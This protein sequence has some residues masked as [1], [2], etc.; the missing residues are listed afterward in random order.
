MEINLRLVWFEHGN[1]E[2]II[3]GARKG[4]NIEI[5]EEGEALNLLRRL[6]NMFI[7]N[8]NHCF[9]VN[10]NNSQMLE[11]H[12]KEEKNIKKLNFLSWIFE[13]NLVD[14]VS[15][16]E[17]YYTGPDI[18]YREFMTPG[19]YLADHCINQIM[20]IQRKTDPHISLGMLNLFSTLSR[21]ER[22]QQPSLVDI[23]REVSPE[24][25]DLKKEDPVKEEEMQ[26]QRR[27][28]LNVF[29]EES[30]SIKKKR[31]L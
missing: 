17:D 28:E 11:I 4:P 23:K 31:R 24:K 19:L 16:A 30:V 7:Q 1:V 10:N 21:Q 3:T 6:Q 8:L 27:R 25:E 5:E 26:E 15:T 18:L 14:Q 20:N 9:V 22:E 2:K 13:C 29:L 12:C